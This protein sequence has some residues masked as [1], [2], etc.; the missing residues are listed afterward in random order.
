MLFVL[1]LRIMEP[2]EIKQTEIDNPGIT[3]WRLKKYVSH[4]INALEVIAREHEKVH[5]GTMEWEIENAAFYRGV[6]EVI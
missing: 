3:K 1:T 6:C 4:D 2:I 5:S